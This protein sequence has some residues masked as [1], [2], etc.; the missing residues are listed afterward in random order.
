MFLIRKKVYFFSTYV[1]IKCD[2]VIYI[3][4]LLKMDFPSLKFL[5]NDKTLAITDFKIY[6][7]ITI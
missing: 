5:N 3:V 6:E 1:D 4:I 7:T 2:I